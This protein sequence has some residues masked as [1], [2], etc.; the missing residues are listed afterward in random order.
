MVEAEIALNHL[1][2]QLFQL[3]SLLYLLLI[4][5]RFVVQVVEL[6]RQLLR[7]VHQGLPNPEISYRREGRLGV[8]RRR[9]EEWIVPNVVKDDLVHLF[10]FQRVFRRGRRMHHMKSRY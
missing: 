5:A 9:H 1:L 2:L 3:L 7:N 8:S 10:D 4:T 6:E